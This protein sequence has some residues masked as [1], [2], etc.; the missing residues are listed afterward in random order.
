MDK[1]ALLIVNPRSGKGEIKNKLLQ[2]VTLFTKEGYSVTVHPT[3]CQYDAF[4]T[5]KDLAGNYDLLVCCGGDGTLNETVNGLLKS[6]CNPTLGYIPAGT[7]ND[8]ASSLNLPK[9]MIKAAEVVLTGEEFAC[10]IGSFNDKYFAYVAAF[11]IFTDVSYQTSQQFKN[12]LGRL[13]YLLEGVK[14]I[15]A[16]EAY[17]LTITCDSETIEDDF[18]LG[19]ITNSTSVAGLKGISHQHALLDDG[20]FEV[21][22]IKMPSTLLELQIIINSMVTND[23]NEKFIHIYKASHIKI[24]SA[25]PVPWTLD[26]EFGG[27]ETEITIKNHQKRL[28][29][30][31]A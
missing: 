22:L 23:L 19:L 8:F 10:D 31:K 21:L 24:S 9:N 4:Q 17:H 18:M 2:I 26:G 28:H 20:L 30:M 6:G 7:V 3:S 29:I 12:M 16:I 1:T 27:E 5:A 14:R 13:A 25:T 15:G 11:G